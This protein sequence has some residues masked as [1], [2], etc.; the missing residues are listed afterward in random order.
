[1]KSV[2]VV[3]PKGCGKTTNKD[4]LAAAYGA[5]RVIDNW[6]PSDPAPMADTIMLTDQY[7]DIITPMFIVVDYV[8]AIRLI[9]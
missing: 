7:P 1:M 5:T 2:I 8:D 4:A 6:Q 3:G 9:K